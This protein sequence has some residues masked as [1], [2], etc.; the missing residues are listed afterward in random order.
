MLKK[1]KSW[2]LIGK[3]TWRIAKW[4]KKHKFEKLEEAALRT[5]VSRAYY[6]AYH[7]AFSY[8]TKK[9][10][11]RI[12]GQSHHD[13]VLQLLDKHDEETTAALLGGLKVKRQ[14]CDY[15]DNVRLDSPLILECFKHAEWIIKKLKV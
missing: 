15:N 3:S 14:W 4:L 12:T 1:L 13:Q 7:F 5:A 8:L 6:A 2:P 9:F 10:N 11:E